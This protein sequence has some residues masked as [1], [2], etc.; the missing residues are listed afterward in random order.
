MRLHEFVAAHADEEVDVGEGELGLT[1][2]ERMP[3]VEE[4]V[5]ACV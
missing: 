2:L 1:E 5:D 3:E 4:V